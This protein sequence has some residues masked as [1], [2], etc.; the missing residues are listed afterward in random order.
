VGRKGPATL[1]AAAPPPDPLPPP[2]QDAERRA[3]GDCQLLS[4]PAQIKRAQKFFFYLN[5]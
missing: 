2:P 3:L 1:P 5:L 4:R